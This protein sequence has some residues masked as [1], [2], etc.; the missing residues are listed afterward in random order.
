MSLNE[1]T[2]GGEVAY[3]VAEWEH[4]ARLHASV[5]TSVQ[6]ALYR[7]ACHYLS[8][9]VADCG[10]GS[11][12]IAPLLADNSQVTAY[13]GID[14]AQEMVAVAQQVVQTLHRPSFKVLHHKIEEVEGRFDSAVS[15]H[16]YY[17]WPD[18]LL[19]LKHI[20]AMLAEGGKFVLAT[21]NQY[22]CMAKLL[23]EA[24]KE[25][26]AHPDFDAFRRYNLQLASK[27]LANFISMDGLVKHAQAAGFGLVECHQRHF[28]GGV[29]FLVLQK[30]P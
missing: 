19:T 8:G 24:E 29:N 11:A 27:P 25:L 1:F 9:S 28:G 6:L 17:S 21:P 12:K 14:Y 13:T 10:C 16:S 4:Y 22:L 15:I 18:P 26:V 30:E 7:D 2:S 5:T 20:A 3:T 23:R